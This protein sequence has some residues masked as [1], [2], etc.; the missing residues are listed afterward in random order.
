MR[1]RDRER[2]SHPRLDDDELFQEAIDLI[3]R[4]QNDP[5]NEISEELIRRWRQRSPT[6]DTVWR[7]AM[8]LHSLAG[9]AIVN[10]RRK[11]A[12]I[13]GKVSRRRMMLASGGA[14]AALTIGSIYIP[15]L[16]LRSQADFLT[17]TAEVQLFHLP[18][19]TIATLGPDSAIRM[20]FSPER[21]GVELLAG[22]AFFEVA[23]DPKRPFQA[24]AEGLTATALG[25]AF[26]LREDAGFLAVSVDHGLVEARMPASPIVNGITLAAGEW[27]RLDVDSLAVERGKREASQ[28]AAWREGMIV[29]DNDTIESVVAQIRRW[30]SG[31]IVFA[32][33]SLASRRI[34]GL[35]DLNKPLLALAAV[36]EPYGGRV[37]RISPLL[38]L[39][40]PI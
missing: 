28:I 15:P 3:V 25:T 18:D 14:V 12:G 26:D 32:D 36:V 1:L 40:S 5:G 8:S 19:G 10:R 30:H 21:R 11:R 4:F 2:M 38:T 39:I 33:R 6:H 7:Q 37:R 31:R 16:V 17:A 24:V 13:A 34:S 9:K 27:I 20:D 29:A 35:F 22:M 23:Q